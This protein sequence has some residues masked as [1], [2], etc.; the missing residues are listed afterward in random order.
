[1]S[2]G[3][4]FP[5][6]TSTAFLGGGGGSSGTISGTVTL[7]GGGA[8]AGGVIELYSGASLLSSAV[9]NGSG[10]YSFVGVNAGSYTVTIQPPLAYSIADAGSFSITVTGGN[11]STQDFSLLA[12]LFSDNFQ[13]YTTAQLLAASGGTSFF[14]N[15]GGRDKTVNQVGGT[16]AMESATG[17]FGGK[18]ARHDWTAAPWDGIESLGSS[19]TGYCGAHTKNV[20]MQPRFNPYVGTLT[21]V[22]FRWTDKYSAGYQAGSASCNGVAS[23]SYKK[24]LVVLED[25]T[26]IGRFGLYLAAPS[27]GIAS[28]VTMDMNDFGGGHAYQPI[29]SVSFTSN[30]WTTWVLG[31][32]GISTTACAMKLYKDGTLVQTLDHDPVTPFGTCQF[33]PGTPVTNWA[34]TMEMGAN[35]NHG[36]DAAQT[37]WWSELGAYLTRPSLRAQAAT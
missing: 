33:W 9:P 35:T 20:S 1:L 34:L 10:N 26:H 30:V 3:I 11:T 2:F 36:P 27:S 23:S 5:G 8:I 25:S 4:G 14:T 28:S 37:R 16:I 13:N 21:E 6:V 15:V 24:F 7:S 31:I 32:T 29:A 22:W 19:S 17:P 12:A 18:T